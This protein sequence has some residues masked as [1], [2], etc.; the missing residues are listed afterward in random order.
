LTSCV[1]R[2]AAL[3][4]VGVT[5]LAA[6]PSEAEVA[7]P[8]VVCRDSPEM[9][10][11]LVQEQIPSDFF[12]VGRRGDAPSGNT[13]ED[14]STIS[15]NVPGYSSS[16]TGH[17]GENDPSHPVIRTGFERLAALFDGQPPAC[18]RKFVVDGSAIQ[19]DP[20]A[21]HCPG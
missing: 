9:F 21:T 5:L 13:L 15:G 10:G 19:P 4:A 20:Q 1:R 12:T 8:K 16:F 14:T 18:F 7:H 17:G 2:L 11:R 6:A 3:A